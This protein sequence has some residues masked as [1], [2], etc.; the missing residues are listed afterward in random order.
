M[1]LDPA[2]KLARYLV[3]FGDN[4]RGENCKEE[5]R[6]R[7]CINP[8]NA[9]GARLNNY[10]L[11]SVG[12]SNVSCLLYNLSKRFINFPVSLQCNMVVIWWQVSGGWLAGDGLLSHDF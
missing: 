12:K 4:V 2:A 1:T 9:L 3:R 11:Q 10:L 8:P 6:I 5:Y 7:G